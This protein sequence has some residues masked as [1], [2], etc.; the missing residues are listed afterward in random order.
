MVFSGWLT[1]AAAGTSAFLLL[2]LGA[3]AAPVFLGSTF[4]VA[5]L[6]GSRRPR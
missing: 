1:A 3:P 5:W 4:A 2:A 6:W